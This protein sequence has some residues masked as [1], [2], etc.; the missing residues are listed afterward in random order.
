MSE[1][2]NLFI[3]GYYVENHKNIKIKL[4]ESFRYLFSLIDEVIDKDTLTS[5]KNKL[6]TINVAQENISGYA[7]ALHTYLIDYI[8]NKSIDKITTL[9][10]ELEKA[11]LLIYGLKIYGFDPNNL[12]LH[13]FELYKDIFLQDDKYKMSFSNPSKN[14]E[15]QAKEKISTALL[16]IKKGRQKFIQ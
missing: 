14:N 13:K 9:I 15:Q 8:E 11:G 6:Y 1:T 10:Q 2:K 16:L 4:T 5:C 7:H 12:G 3:P